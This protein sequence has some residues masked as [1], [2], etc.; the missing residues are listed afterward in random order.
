VTPAISSIC[1][2][3]TPTGNAWKNSVSSSVELAQALLEQAIC[4]RGRR[5]F[6]IRHVELP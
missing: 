5:L 2:N 4:G 3:R 6:E 1:S